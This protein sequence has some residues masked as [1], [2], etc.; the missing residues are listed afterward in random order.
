MASTNQ[1][2][3][4]ITKTNGYW[5]LMKRPSPIRNAN[6]PSAQHIYCIERKSL[7][8][9][10]QLSVPLRFYYY[11]SPLRYDFPSHSW[12]RKEIDYVTTFRP[13]PD[14]AKKSKFNLKLIE[15]V[16]QWLT[17]STIKS[18]NQFG[19]ENVNEDCIHLWRWKQLALISLKPKN[20]ST[21]FNK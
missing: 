9:L 2:R 14:D 13:V 10:L 6:P 17:I 12:R 15:I 11:D 3:Q 4:P 16:C 1:E 19:V 21:R 7:L 8:L 20:T 18:I 5:E